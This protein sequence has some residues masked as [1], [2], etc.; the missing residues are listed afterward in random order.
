MKN[1]IKIKN[2]LIIGI[3]LS[4]LLISCEDNN[5][6][7]ELSFDLKLTEDGRGYHHLT[8]DRNNWQTLHRV[9][10]SIRDVG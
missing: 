2:N 7:H 4:F 3:I 8:L 9:T 5:T 10:G 6:Y 1:L